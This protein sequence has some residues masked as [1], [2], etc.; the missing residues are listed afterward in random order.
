MLPENKIG[1]RPIPDNTGNL[2]T[3]ESYREYNLNDL[4]VGKVAYIQ[5]IEDKKLQVLQILRIEKNFKVIKLG[6]DISTDYVFSAKITLAE[7][8]K[9]KKKTV[10]VFSRIWSYTQADLGMVT[11]ILVIDRIL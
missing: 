10:G 11:D 6:K 5:Y 8:L 3:A 4:P 7:T 9:A 1:E 2:I